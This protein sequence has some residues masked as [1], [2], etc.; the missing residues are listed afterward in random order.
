MTEALD[1]DAYFAR[2]GY[3]GPREP[4]LAVLRELHLL[5]PRTIPFENLDVL[6]G[7]GVRIDLGSIQSKLVD[8]GSGGEVTEMAAR[9]QWGRPEALLGPR[10]HRFSKGETEEGPFHADVGF[11]GN[12]Q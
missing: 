9:V 4:T 10:T 7:R 5:P 2:I 8:G 6:L 1:L 11:G 3:T 12:T